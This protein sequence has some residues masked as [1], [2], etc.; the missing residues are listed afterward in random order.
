VLILADWLLMV[1]ALPAG[2][3]V[4]YLV[5]LTAFSAR[6][7]R[8][9]QVREVLFFD[10]VVPAH[11]E[12]E[13]IGRTVKNLLALEW[14]LEAFRVLVI[15]D[16]C[17]DQTAARARAAGATVIE[18]QDAKLRGKGYALARAFE[19][20]KQDG[21]AQAVVV[22]D[23]DTVVSANLLQ[24]FAARLEQGALAAQT[25]YGVANPDASWR[26]RLMAIALGMFHKVRSTGRERL[27]LSCGLRG[28]GM[29]FTHRLLDEVPHD[30][31]SVVED[32]EYGIRLGLAGHRVHY[33]AE[34]EVLGEMVSGEKASRSQRT[35]WEGGRKAIRRQHG[36]H[37]FSKGLGERN[38]LLF[39]LGMDVWT[40]PLS[41]LGLWAVFTTTLGAALAYA[42]ASGVALR[43]G[44]V[45]CVG[46][47]LYVLRGW[48]VSGTGW[49]GLGTLAL[50]P[51]Y[52]AWKVIL[53]AKGQTAPP[54]EWVRTQREGETAAGV[55]PP[56]S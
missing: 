41:T 42:G 34:A 43:W 2:V 52:V 10:I 5:L 44:G 54:K 25:H 28:N 55:K 56:E 45:M 48:A 33:A 19:V 31:F 8:S 35:R 39:D 12:E 24:A 29:C 27:G 13:G 51:V 7:S 20:S 17:S 50:A 22:V 16:N 26:T 47:A 36:R 23:A 14:P 9:T 38:A 21:K 4:G 49:R 3:A 1:L 46:L 30:A 15:A 40:P 53:K 18:R 37:L 32:L 11:N 6:L